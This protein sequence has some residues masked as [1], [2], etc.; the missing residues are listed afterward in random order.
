M[1]FH[2]S[3]RGLSVG[4]TLPP[5]GVDGARAALLGPIPGSRVVQ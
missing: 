1:S 5:D 4:N 3:S 2:H